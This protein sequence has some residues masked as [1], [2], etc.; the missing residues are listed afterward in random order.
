MHADATAERPACCCAVSA[1]QRCCSL[2]VLQGRYAAGC[3][4]LLHSS[5]R[6]RGDAGLLLVCCCRC[7]SL[8]T[9]AAAACRQAGP[10]CAC[11]RRQ[12]GCDS[13]GCALAAAARQQHAHAWSRLASRLLSWVPVNLNTRVGRE[14]THVR[15]LR[16]HAEGTPGTVCVCVL[17]ACP[18]P[19]QPGL[20]LP[21]WQVKQ[22][23]NACPDAS[24]S[25]DCAQLGAQRIRTGCG[26]LPGMMHG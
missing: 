11:S 19:D 25:P 8:S 18:S 17:T 23:M 13:S 14:C 1:V 20:Q 2:H 10:G 9:A 7:H 21:C 16:D 12:G 5:S 24:Q 22:V 4:A 6:Y 26:V 3:C 15:Q